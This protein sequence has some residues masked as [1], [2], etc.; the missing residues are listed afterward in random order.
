MTMTPEPL[1]TPCVPFTLRP[2]TDGATEPKM[3]TGSLG[4]WGEPGA[5]ACAA[6]CFVTKTGLGWL[7]APD[8]ISSPPQ[9]RAPTPPEITPTSQVRASGPTNQLPA[10]RLGRPAWTDGLPRTSE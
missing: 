5:G 6:V 2:T 8:A 10:L 4:A 1:E 7:T 3:P 9:T